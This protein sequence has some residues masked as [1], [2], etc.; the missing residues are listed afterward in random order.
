MAMDDESQIAEDFG[1]MVRMVTGASMQLRENQLRARAMQVQSVQRTGTEEARVRANAARVVQHD[2]YSRDFWR[3]AGSES[4][5]DRLAVA[6]ALGSNEPAARSAW[7][8]G[9]D[10]LRSEFGIDLQEINRAHP[11]SL[12]QRHAA[13]RDALDDY[14]AQH[15]QDRADDRAVAEQVQEQEAVAEEPAQVQQPAEDGPELFVMHDL[16]NDRGDIRAV[17]K[18]GA[19]RA[20]ENAPDNLGRDMPEAWADVQGWI[21]R[22]EDVDRAIAEKFPDA[23]TDE[24]RARALGQEPESETYTDTAG[25]AARADEKDA[26]AEAQ[27]D[28]QREEAEAEGDA[29]RVEHLDDLAQ[30]AERD[31]AHL[32]GAEAAQLSK[33]R[34]MQLESFPHGPHVLNPSEVKRAPRKRPAAGVQA[35]AERAEVLSR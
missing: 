13:L 31:V 20:I 12:E 5:A 28:A 33:V 25:V 11:S 19:L 18:D 23:M 27:G 1:M 6:A 15:R 16:S 29:A 2:L 21:G 32:T 24:Q 3:H 4:I 9:A 34:R 17:E 7:M 35:E 30:A 10:V 8:H 26:Q 14:F 22:D